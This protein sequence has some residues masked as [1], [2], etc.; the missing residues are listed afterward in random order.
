MHA[1]RELPGA[2]CRG[3]SGAPRFGLDARMLALLLFGCAGDVEVSSSQSGCVDFDYNDPAEPTVEWET[4]GEASVLAW[5]TNVLRDEAGATFS[6]EYAI[7]NGTLSV[8]E[9]WSD[10]ASDDTFCYQPEVSIGGIK[11][12]LELRWFTEDDGD[13]PYETVTIAL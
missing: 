7:E 11:G 10:P 3:V 8:Y 9:K 1:W 12:K 13:V 5:R 4:T 2:R 6:P